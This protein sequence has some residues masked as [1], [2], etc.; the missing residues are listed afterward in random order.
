MDGLDERVGAADDVRAVFEST[1]ALLCGLAG[2][3]HRVI[4]ANAAYRAA[5]GR[6]DFVGEPLAQMYPEGAGQQL[7]EMADRVYRTGVPQVGQGWRAHVERGPG[8]GQLVE[9]YFDFT[10][11]PRLGPDGTVAGLTYFGLDATDRV[12]EQ[13]RAH[14]ET[15]EAVRRYE[16]A[17]ELITTLQR[18]LLPAGLPVLPSVQ[19]AGSYLLAEAGDAAGGDWFDAVPVP[20]GRVAL[21]VGDVAGH[22]VAASAA[23]GQLRAVLHDRLDETGDPLIAIAAADRMALRVPAARAATVCVVV[24]DPADGTLVHCSAGHPPPLIAGPRES[25]YLP[26]A[27]TGSLGTGATFATATAQLGPD[28]VLLLYSD[29]LVERPGRTPAAATVELAQVAIDAV[30]GR[31]LDDSGLTPVE[32]VCL[33][34][35]ELLVRQT[36]HTDDITLLAARRRVPAPPLRLSLAAERGVVRPARDALVR[37]LL[38][39]GA[40]EAD[41][42]AFAHA[43][44]ELVTNAAEHSHPDTGGGTV[45]VSADLGTDGVARLAVADDGRWQAREKP[46]DEDFRRDHGLGLAMTAGLVDDLRL[47]HGAAGTTITV[48]RRLS[49][50]ATLL[51]TGE[52]SHG[53]AFRPAD[54][55]PATLFR[56]EPAAPGNRLAVHGPLDAVNT[57]RLAA[58]LGRLTLGGTHDLVV[59]LSA[60]T[61]LASAAVAVLYRSPALRMYAP[62]GSLAQHV[63][64]LAGLPHTTADPHRSE[65]PA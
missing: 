17:R 60:V 14:L 34:G 23:M 45:T 13:Q 19:L 61:H 24:L 50:P 63:L 21:V 26:C 5:L 59:D 32:R 49:C 46:G 10:M 30:A 58:E 4:A 55:Q 40:G 8:S 15:V 54:P 7:F 53:A 41:L 11:A 29:G 44:V 38:D 64:T 37:W 48:R 65:D 28:E 2:P 25:R 1:P 62:A 18:Q 36:G 39:Q 3:E 42:S 51:T 52:I 31:G 57:D 9:M 33:H 43:A 16:D 35:I 6:S 47:D 56:G 12:L 22:G 20:G 27:G